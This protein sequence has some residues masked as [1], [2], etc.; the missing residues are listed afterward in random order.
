MDCYANRASTTLIIKGFSKS[1][2]SG[3]FLCI[4][5]S[6]NIHEIT[7]CRHLTLAAFFH[8]SHEGWGRI[9]LQI[10]FRGW[11][12]LQASWCSCSS[13][14]CIIA[15]EKQKFGGLGFRNYIDKK[16]KHTYR[17]TSWPWS[18][19]CV[20]SPVDVLM[21]NEGCEK[22][23]NCIYMKLLSIVKFTFNKGR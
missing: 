7:T 19:L 9:A 18:S 14:A 22:L 15:H 11:F 2:K 23:E 4:L 10:A 13:L 5:N 16:S 6:F 1:F 12:A 8:L 21:Y 3:Q 17:I 20:A